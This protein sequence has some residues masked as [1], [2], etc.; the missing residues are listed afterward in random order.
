MDTI[1]K[2][3]SKLILSCADKLC[4]RYDCSQLR[5]DLISVGNLELLK[6]VRD[7]DSGAGASMATYLYPYLLGAMRREVEKNLY[8]ISLP[9]DE[10]QAQGSAWRTAFSSLA[11]H[12][13]TE[14]PTILPLEQQVLREVY[15]TCIWDEFEKLSFKERQI[16][17]GFFGLYGC[18]KQT[19]TE[20]AEEFQQT[21]NGLIKAKDKALQKLRKLCEEGRLGIWRQ[22]VSAIRA[23]KRE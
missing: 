22:A 15:L 14:A 8:P 4:R 18:P 6:K 17:G 5:E 11:E 19:V 23:A 2:E 7:Y 20:L 21:E 12:T 1:L 16:L 13:E 3:H 9:K 10:F